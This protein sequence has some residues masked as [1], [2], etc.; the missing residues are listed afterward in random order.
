M[1]KY[2]ENERPNK[3]NRN[4]PSVH[5]T[6]DN[7]H[8][9]IP[10]TDAK[11]PDTDANIPDTD[12]K[13]PDTDAKLPENQAMVVNKVIKKKGFLKRFVGVIRSLFCYG[14]KTHNTE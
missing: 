1:K 3:E 2:W 7:W 10:D 4:V 14:S 6:S 12:A 13:I 9:K 5:G 8:A 11:I